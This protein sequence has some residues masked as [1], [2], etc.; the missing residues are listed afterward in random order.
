MVPVLLHRN[1]AEI[2]GKLPILNSLDKKVGDLWFIIE[3]EFHIFK[4]TYNVTL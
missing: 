2:R 1:M 4:L 3:V